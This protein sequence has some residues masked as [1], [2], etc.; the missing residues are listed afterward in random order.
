MSLKA[1]ALQ[2]RFQIRALKT[3]LC[4]QRCVCCDCFP[5]RAATLFFCVFVFERLNRTLARF[6][7]SLE[8]RNVE[9]AK[10]SKKTALQTIRRFH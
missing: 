2:E 5:L 6:F 4:A 1:F 8:R 3:A 10:Q 9:T 7:L